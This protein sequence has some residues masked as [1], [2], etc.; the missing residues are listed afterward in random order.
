MMSFLRGRTW[1]PKRA[2]GWMRKTHTTMRADLSIVA[3]LI[4]YDILANLAL[5]H[6]SVIPSLI[7]WCD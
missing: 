1:P 7:M 6:L 3:E 4:E 5:Y 2:E